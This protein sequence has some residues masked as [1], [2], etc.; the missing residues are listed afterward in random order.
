MNRDQLEEDPSHS[1]PQLTFPSVEINSAVARSIH[2]ALIMRSG[3]DHAEESMS[4]LDDSAYEILSETTALTSDDEG[5][6]DNPESLVS[7]NVHTPD[8]VASLADTDESHDNID[9]DSESEQDGP[10]PN[11]ASDSGLTARDSVHTRFL[12]SSQE[13]LPPPGSAP[14][15]V[16]LSCRTFAGTHMPEVLRRYGKP[17]V[18]LTVRLGMLGSE[19]AVDRPFRILYVGDTSGQVKSRIISK[20]ASALAVGAYH[21]RDTYASPARLNAV[22]VSASGVSGTPEVELFESIGVEL[23]VDDCT[24]AYQ[25]DDNLTLVLNHETQVHFHS[26]PTRSLKQGMK[27]YPQDTFQVPDLAV[28]YHSAPS[29]STREHTSAMDERWFA[30]VSQAMDTLSV[31]KWNIS[32]APLYHERPSGFT[33]TEWDLQLRVDASGTA[34]VTEVLDVLPVDVANFLDINADQLNR[35]LACLTEVRKAQ[36]GFELS[37]H[38]ASSFRQ[39]FRSWVARPSSETYKTLK[40]LITSPR[41]RFFAVLLLITTLLV[42]LIPRHLMVDLP[43]T[44]VTTEEA[45]YNG[46]LDVALA[47]LVNSGT[48]IPPLA[49][50]VVDSQT[51][52]ATGKKQTPKGKKENQGVEKSERGVLAIDT[53]AG[54]A[55]QKTIPPPQFE[56][57]KVG[58]CHMLITP[59]KVVKGSHRNPQISVTVVRGQEAVDA[60]LSVLRKGIYAVEL[61]QE[62]AYGSVLVKVQ[63]V[64][65]PTTKESFKLDLGSRHPKL[66]DWYEA[67]TT[68]PSEDHVKRDKIWAYLERELQQI[69]VQFSLII[70]STEGTVEKFLATGKAAL[71]LCQQKAASVEEKISKI[72][73]E[74]YQMRWTGSTTT[75]K[76]R[77][78]ELRNSLFKELTARSERFRFNPFNPNRSF[79]PIS[80]RLM[81]GQQQQKKLGQAVGKARRHA[82]QVWKRM[83]ELA[84]AARARHSQRNGCS[85][86]CSAPAKVDRKGMLQR[87]RRY[88]KE[89]RRQARR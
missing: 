85:S 71:R 19:L 29:S 22:P 50:E 33:P 66:L 88:R 82:H 70:N 25:Q 83:Q 67:V 79:R 87:L 65:T 44:E 7:F 38:F 4:A 45:Q 15:P 59:S 16:E 34:G 56:L 40:H 84:V 28:F 35:H 86:E 60:K 11:E 68:W 55:L 43:H 42:C 5:Q 48:A 24:D 23:C 53:R 32:A 47:A 63:S 3:S 51:A 2:T 21:T 54:S 20:I 57:H 69:P 49:R 41:S 30:H 61:S 74:K 80:K 62:D 58:C 12:V 36:W 52:T 10:L 46:S 81:L 6:D 78:S 75:M 9:T 8:D 13:A 27:S 14:R 18:N 73:T 37:T 72:A 26:H 64:A 76:E 31:P 89:A 77:I 39:R 17:S 1:P